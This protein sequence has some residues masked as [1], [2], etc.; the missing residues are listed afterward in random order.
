MEKETKKI[1][2]EN[3]KKN[4]ML[5]NILGGKISFRE[6]EEIL[7]RQVKKFGSGS[8]HVLIPKKHIDAECQ[9]TIW[10]KEEDK[11]D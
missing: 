7:Q 4:S 2:E 8:A 11:K 9:I 1:E 10:K 3:K 5:M 6:P